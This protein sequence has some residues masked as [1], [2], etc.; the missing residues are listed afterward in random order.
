MFLPLPFLWMSAPPLI[1]TRQLISDLY[2]STSTVA[3]LSCCSLTTSSVCVLRPV[4]AAVVSW[5]HQTR[6][7]ADAA[8]LSLAVGS[9]YL[10]LKKKKKT[11]HDIL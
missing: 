4:R 5:S 6:A 7:D 8:L 9:S 2:T 11:T 10:S 3:H 1:A